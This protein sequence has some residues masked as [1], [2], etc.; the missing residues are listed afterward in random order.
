MTEPHMEYASRIPKEVRLA[1]DGLSDRN[2]VGY[3]VVMLL[4]EK[5]S[6]SFSEI[7]DELDVHQQSLSNTLDALQRGGIIKKEAGERI[8]DQSTGDYTITEFGDR[9]LDGLYHASQA[10]SEMDVYEAIDII[11]D[12]LTQSQP[13]DEESNQ[14]LSRSVSKTAQQ[15]V[16]QD[17]SNSQESSVG[18]LPPSPLGT[19][20]DEGPIGDPSSSGFPDQLGRLGLDA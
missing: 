7:Q 4:V 18:E 15:I 16:A 1:I 3:G 8:G 12:K 9:V 19:N 2:E 13:I 6:L 5:G 20:D 17:V 11:L 10:N 14:S